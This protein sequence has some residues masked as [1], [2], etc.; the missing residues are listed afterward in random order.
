MY[1]PGSTFKPVTAL[2]GLAAGRG[3]DEVYECVGAFELGLLHLRCTAIYGHGPL[4]LRHAIMKSCNPFFCDMGMFAGTNAL[5]AAAHS[6]GLG[7]K[8]GLALGADAAGVVPDAEW[9]MRAYGE[10]W[11]QG[12]LAQMS[13][14]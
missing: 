12:D 14:G 11:Y 9:K 10:K 1:A 13:I 6:L 5:V 2:A 4:D 8:A 7:R 3:A